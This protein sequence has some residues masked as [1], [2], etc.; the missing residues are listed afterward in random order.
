VTG[1]IIGCGRIVQDHHVPAWQTLGREAV[2]EWTIADP[3]S[4]SRYAVQMALGVP[5]G[6]AYRDYRALLIREKPDFVVVC[7][8]HAS[9]ESIV[10][11]CIAAGIPVL[12][13]KP[14]A[15][16]LAAARRMIDAAEK[17]GIPLAVLP[18]VRD[19]GDD[20]VAHLPP[21]AVLHSIVGTDSA[22]KRGNVPGVV[23]QMIGANGQPRFPPL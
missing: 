21:E 6:H 4:Q 15:A 19:P 2:R 16:S 14:M 11:D 13:E 12:V 3:T 5:M 8:P 9:H 17:A 20:A 18:E 7:T 10:L 1:A 22:D 23:G